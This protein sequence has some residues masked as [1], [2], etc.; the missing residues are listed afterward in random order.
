MYRVMGRTL[1]QRWWCASGLWSYSPS[2]AR[3]KLQASTIS[4][5]TPSTSQVIYMYTLIDVAKKR[6][7]LARKSSHLAKKRPHLEKKC[8]FYSS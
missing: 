3:Q 7:H 2:E 1:A 4:S 8:H 5:D 6:P